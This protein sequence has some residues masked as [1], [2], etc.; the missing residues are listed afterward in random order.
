MA[1]L[2]GHADALSATAATA[3]IRVSM[4]TG[5]V[6]TRLL[7]EEHGDR[8]CVDGGELLHVFSTVPEPKGREP[9]PAD[10]AVAALDAFLTELSD[11]DADGA[12]DLVCEA[13]RDDY[14]EE[15]DQAA[16]SGRA[17]SLPDVHRRSEGTVV[18]KLG[19]EPGTGGAVGV[20]TVFGQR[21][22]VNF[23]EIH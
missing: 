21:W 5:S 20:T 23:V 16:N 1:E 22:C 19:N 18:G 4:P 15:I 8:W 12:H 17:L 11:R 2:I 13:H 3:T 10:P 14:T 6:A 7:I 9:D